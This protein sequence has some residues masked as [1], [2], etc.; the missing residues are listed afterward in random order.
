MFAHC[1]TRSRVPIIPLP[2]IS[3]SGF[4]FDTWQSGSIE[5]QKSTVI[6]AN[7]LLC[8]GLAELSILNTRYVPAI[9]DVGNP[10]FFLPVCVENIC[11]DGFSL[12]E[13]L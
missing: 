12:T 10:R 3:L 11:F 7:C 8:I 2:G 9:T 4:A 1:D 6:R 13:S 5:G